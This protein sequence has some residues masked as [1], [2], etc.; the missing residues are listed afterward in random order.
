MNK[1]FLPYII[2]VPNLGVGILWAMNMT[3]IPEVVNDNQL[4]LANGFSKV[5]SVAGGGLYL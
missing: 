4:G 5:V 2:G 3:L 1:K